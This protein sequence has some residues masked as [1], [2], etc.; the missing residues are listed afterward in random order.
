MSI[1][2]TF[3]DD[4]RG[5]II[6]CLDH[7]VLA[8]RGHEHEHRIRT[9]ENCND[10]NQEAVSRIHFGSAIQPYEWISS[11]AYLPFCEVDVIIGT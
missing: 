5:I 7:C 4:S 9:S 3:A 1:S 6:T 10:S 2:Y 8:R 11:L